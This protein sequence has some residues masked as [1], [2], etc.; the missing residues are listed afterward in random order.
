MTMIAGAA[1]IGSDAFSITLEISSVLNSTYDLGC[2]HFENSSV[3]NS[4]YVFDAT[5]NGAAMNAKHHL[6]RNQCDS[7]TPNAVIR[8]KDNTAG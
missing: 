2:E 5:E 1:A 4:A 7:K 8:S 3:L 6:R